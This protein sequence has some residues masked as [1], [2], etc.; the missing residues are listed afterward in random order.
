MQ[1]TLL[2]L[3]LVNR[4]EFVSTSKIIDELWGRRPPHSAAAAVQMY[5][6][7]IR[8]ILLPGRSAPSGGFDRHPVLCTRQAGY[9]LLVDA[10]QLDLTR[11][12]TLADRGRAELANGN[13]ARATELF[14]LALEMWRGPALADVRRT[15]TLDLYARRLDEERRTLLLERLW[16]D[17]RHG[18]NHLIVGE[19]TDL[20]AENPLREAFQHQLMLALALSGRRVEA[21]DVYA[22]TYRTMVEE[23]GI[24]P[25]GGMRAAQE[26]LLSDSPTAIWTHVLN[27][28][29]FAATGCGCVSLLKSCY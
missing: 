20:C 18:R 19:L 10:E 21:L 2:S 26:A 24:G 6:S 4:N 15:D 3:L 9:S 13:C 11:F 29:A 1:R 25:G 16:Q 8:R 5:V 7:A 12:R 22:R 14:G 28:S 23:V 17:L 27:E